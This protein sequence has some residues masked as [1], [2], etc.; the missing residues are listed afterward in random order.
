MRSLVIALLAC[1]LAGQA[2]AQQ[3]VKICVPVVN[4]QGAASCQDV[5][6]AIGPGGTIAFPVVPS[7]IAVAPVV[8][9]A[10]ES[11]HILKGA[12][13]ALGQLTV[14][15]GATS[16][17]VLVIDEV[18]IAANGATVPKWWWPITSNGTNGALSVMFSPALTFVNGIVAAF[19]TT[20]PFTQT[21]SATA[22][23][24]GTVQ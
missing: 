17:W 11:S 20:G 16:G 12:A 24:S 8:S 22:A 5:P 21:L 9:T 3:T 14:T 19:S 10:T 2:S 18:A 4:A 23:F 1:L 15:I 6:G 7:G 13:G